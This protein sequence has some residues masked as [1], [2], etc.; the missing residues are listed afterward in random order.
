MIIGLDIGTSSVKGVL[1]SKEGKIQKT[2]RGTFAYTKLENGGLE[3]TADDFT[4]VCCSI[5]KE[6]AEATEKPVLG[7]CASSASGNLLVLDKNN[8]PVT[9]IFNWQDQRVATEVKEI[10]G[11]IDLDELYGRVGWP[12]DQKTFP[13]ALLCYVRIHTPKKLSDCGMVCMSTEYLYYKLTGR[14]GISPSAGTPFYLLDQRTGKYIPELLDRLDICESQLPPVMPCGKILGGVTEE[15]AKITGLTVGTPI[16]LGSFDHP[17]AARGVG[18]SKEGE[19]LLSCGTSW[20]GFVPV[21]DRNKAIEA[22]LLV[23]P[24]LSADGG[25]WAAM[26]SLPSLSERIR[27]YVNRYIDTSENA[28][29]ILS[30]LAAK[31]VS[32][33]NGLCICPVEE[34]NDDKVAGC[35]TE[36]IARAIM[37][38]TVRLLKKKLDELAERNMKAASAVM[39]GGPSVDPMWHKLIEE[40]CG[41]KVRVLHGAHAGAVGAAMLA[42]I[43]VGIYQDEAEADAICN[44]KKGD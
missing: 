40:I 14:W 43:G 8:R 22:K 28:Y 41:V 6:L 2:A 38:G 44:G 4:A 29:H 9:P 7:I 27:L 3:I 33:A 23:D 13:L 42:G 39:V 25:N 30:D 26:F 11:E 36:D 34:P 16:V 10:L 12:F 31:S 19:M 18:V 35:S 24:F 37:E 20:V 21:T 17:S 32:G 15:G 1:M 5:I